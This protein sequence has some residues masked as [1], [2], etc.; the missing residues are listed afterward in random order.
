MFSIK[1]PLKNTQ[2]VF[3]LEQIC[4]SSSTFKGRSMCGISGKEDQQETFL[5]GCFGKLSNGNICVRL[6][7][8]VCH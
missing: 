6:S 1:L 2:A 8:Q 3:P 7:E 4:E 5:E